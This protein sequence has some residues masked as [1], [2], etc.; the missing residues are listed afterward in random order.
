MHEILKKEIIKKVSITKERKKIKVWWQDGS[1]YTVACPQ[2][3]WPEQS[4]W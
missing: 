4:A 1:M 2:V 3:W